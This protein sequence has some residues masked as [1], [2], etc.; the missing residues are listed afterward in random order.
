M[1]AAP[2]ISRLLATCGQL[3]DAHLLERGQVQA[4]LIASRGRGR[5]DAPGRAGL[6]GRVGA[7]RGLRRDRGRARPRGLDRSRR[8]RRGGL[9]LLGRDRGLGAR[10]LARP[11]GARILAAWPAAPRRRGSL[12][13]GRRFFFGHVGLDGVGREKGRR[14]PVCFRRDFATGYEYVRGIGRPVSIPA[15]TAGAWPATGPDRLVPSPH[16]GSAPEPQP[17]RG[18]PRRSDARWDRASDPG[19]AG[20]APGTARPCP[21]A[22]FPSGWARST[23]RR[24]RASPRGTRGAPNGRRERSRRLPCA[25]R[26]RPVRSAGT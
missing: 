4:V 25:Q 11:L 15:R 9:R 8:L 1:A 24:T 2:G 26:R 10:L 17:P 5:S 12:G 20:P 16:R 14:G 6:A 18:D 13:A 23:G 7:D 19:G 3:R 22:G 21:P